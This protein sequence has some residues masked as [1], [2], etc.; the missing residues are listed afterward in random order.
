MAFASVLEATKSG[1]DFAEVVKEY[2]DN[3]IDKETGG[4]M[5]WIDR[6]GEFRL[7]YNQAEKVEIGQVATELVETRNSL[8][9]I[10]VNDKREN[11]EEVNA[12]HLLICYKGMDRCENEITQEEDLEIINGLK[13]RASSETFV[14]LV[15]ENSTEP[16]AESSGCDLGWFR[17]GQNVPEFEEVVFS[18]ETGTV[19]EVVETQFG[20]HLIYKEDQRPI[21]EYKLAR[22][23]IQTKTELDIL[24]PQDPWKNTGLTG[25]HL[26]K[27][28]VEFD[29]NTTAV[30]V[31][32][33]FN[34]EGKKLFADITERNVNKSIAILIDGMSPVDTNGNGEIDQFDVYAPRVNEPIKEGK[35]SITGNF[36]INE[37][38]EL[39]I[40]LNAGALPVPI[41][42]I[43][44][45]TIG[46]SLGLESIQKSL[47]AGIVGLIIVAIFMLGFY[48]LPGLVAVVA[49][50]VYGVFRK[51]RLKNR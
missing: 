18:M 50:M 33:E 29:P 45:Q 31:S 41:K 30:T 12:R 14:A 32:L 48:R 49:L 8:N 15:K 11:G 13:E 37:A 36:D 4:D 6:I 7:F 23:Y 40:N 38:R 28:R 16:G 25:A 24:P 46:A 19:S 34:N 26:E 47:L 35:A 1:Q 10:K 21:T 17:K 2:S 39:S 44:Q 20:Y 42:L 27:S 51:P 3:E 5:G 9:I 22:V 43:S